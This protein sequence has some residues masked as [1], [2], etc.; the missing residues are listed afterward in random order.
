MRRRHCDI[1]ASRLERSGHWNTI[2]S[3]KMDT[4]IDETIGNNLINSDRD[5]FVTD[6][7][8]LSKNYENISPDSS[9][10]VL[11]Q[12]MFMLFTRVVFN[13]DLYIYSYNICESFL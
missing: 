11:I 9:S 7:D 12:G 1:E 13:F 10:R 2:F 5:D 8:Y 6:E 3:I 4:N